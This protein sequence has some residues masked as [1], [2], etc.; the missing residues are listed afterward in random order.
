[1]K[2]RRYIFTFCGGQ[3]EIASP[4]IIT[5]ITKDLILHTTG[6]YDVELV[7]K[8]S[9]P[10]LEIP[11]I[12][13]LDQCTNLLELNLS[14]N[15]ITEISGLSCLSKLRRLDLSRNY[16]HSISDDALNSNR[17]LEFLS[18]E[19]NVI[20]DVDDLKSLTSLS[21]L[22]CLY[23][24]NSKKDVTNPVCQ[25]PGY[26]NVTSDCLKQLTI[27]DGESLEL[28]KEVGKTF[29]DCDSD[30]LRPDKKYEEELD[31]GELAQKRAE[32]KDSA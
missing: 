13:S 26:F 25:F 10:Y 24:Q 15:S 16:I 3:F 21:N 30:H 11:R 12:S 1:L 29:T 31:T 23:M 6:E 2:K 5:M 32:S 27:L 14:H 7:L 28:K 20:T 18:L 22:R 9:L 17:A 8:L 19:G 4:L